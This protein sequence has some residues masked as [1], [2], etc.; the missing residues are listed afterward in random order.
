MSQ[1]SIPVIGDGPFPLDPRFVERFEKTEVKM[2]LASELME[3]VYSGELGGVDGLC[4]MLAEA[5]DELT[6]MLAAIRKAEADCTAK[7]SEEVGHA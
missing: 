7:P 1:L 3:F 2:R 4:Q 6:A 5:S